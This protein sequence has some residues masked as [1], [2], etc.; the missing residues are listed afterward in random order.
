MLLDSLMSWYGVVLGPLRK[1]ENLSLGSGHQVV[2]LGCNHPAESSRK[3]PEGPVLGLCLYTRPF[4]HKLK[5]GGLGYT[6]TDSFPDTVN[7]D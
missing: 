4:E 1:R 2:L 7:T 3:K 6:L 5:L